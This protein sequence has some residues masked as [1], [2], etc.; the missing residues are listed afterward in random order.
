MQPVI[1]GDSVLEEVT[2]HQTWTEIRLASLLIIIS[3]LLTVNLPLTYSIAQ[4]GQG[5][6]MSVSARGISSEDIGS[7]L[8]QRR[9]I[10]GFI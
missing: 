10:T 2:L 3:P 8:S 7:G 1:A 9:T 4:I 5:I 6:I